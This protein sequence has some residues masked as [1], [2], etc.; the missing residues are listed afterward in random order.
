MAGRRTYLGIGLSL[1]LL[2]A[3][4]AGA[5]TI[6]VTVSS[7][8]ELGVEVSQSGQFEATDPDEDGIFTYS[9]GDL[10]GNVGSTGRWD[11]TG[12]SGF[13]NTDPTI[14]SSFDVTNLLSGTQTFTI[15]VST[16]TGPIGP[17]TL[18]GGSAQG[19]VTDADGDG[20]TLSTSGVGAAFYTSLLDGADFAG[21]YADPSSVTV[22]AFLSDNLAPVENF[23]TPI[24][25]FPGPAVV[26]SIGIRF[27][28]DLTGSD[29]ATGSGVFVVEPVPEPATGLL[30]GLGLVALARTRRRRQSTAYPSKRRELTARS[31]DA[32]RPG[33]L[34]A[35]GRMS[36]G[37]KTPTVT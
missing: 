10:P 24:P 23:G 16:V 33:R 31:W 18:T 5:I 2:L 12:W 37:T 28:F 8:D 29:K 22:G 13:F 14:S 34:H 35:P 6:D 25:S 36:W 4:P 15:T 30:L 1:S 21:L 32:R 19:G 3:L 7:I 11:I 27:E 17:T 9:L 20:A 26:S